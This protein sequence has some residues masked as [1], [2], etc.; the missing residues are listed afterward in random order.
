LIH[1]FR[2]LKMCK[3]ILFRLLH[4]HQELLFL[5]PRSFIFYIKKLFVRLTA[6][7]AQVFDGEVV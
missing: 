3:Y 7:D 5:S 2:A 4:A 1:S 6:D